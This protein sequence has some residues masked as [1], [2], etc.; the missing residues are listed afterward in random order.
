[1]K[2]TIFIFIFLFLILALA[3][4]DY[5]KI[6]ELDKDATESEIKKAFRRL[7]VKFHPDKNPGDQESAQRYL[8]V[9]KAY[10]VL[11]DQEK[12]QMYDLYGEEGIF[13]FLNCY[14][15]N[16]VLKWGYN[17]YIFLFNFF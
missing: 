1:M 9:N 8:K 11:N 13:T 2:K 6:L 12:K 4:E 3:E 15:N 7:S 16:K 14:S 5:Y 10:E 17:F